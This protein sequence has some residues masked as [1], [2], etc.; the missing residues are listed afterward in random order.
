MELFSPIYNISF[1]GGM[2]PYVLI[3]SVLSKHAAEFSTEC[4][5]WKSSSSSGVQFYYGNVQLFQCVLQKSTH[6]HCMYM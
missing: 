2:G 4:G 3:S 6:P 5:T 1:T